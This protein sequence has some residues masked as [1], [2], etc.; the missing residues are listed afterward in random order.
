MDMLILVRQLARAVFAR[1]KK[2]IVFTT[3]IGLAALVPLAYI[4]SR[5]PPRFST[6]ATILLESRPDRTPLFQEFSPFRP[7]SVQMAILRSRSLAESVIAALPRA[8][9][10]DLVQNPYSRDYLLELKN[11]FRRLRG[12][13]PVVESPQRRAI[14]ELQN[15]RV[16]FFGATRDGIIQVQ[17]EASNARVATDIASTFIEVL[18]SRTRS[19]NVDDTRATRDFLEQQSSQLK[20]AAAASEENLRQFT[21]ARGGVKVPARSAETLNRIAQLE[22]ALAEV[23]SNRRMTQSRLTAMRSK[24]DAMPAAPPPRAPE[25]KG[26]P[27]PAQHTARI[28]RLQARLASLEGQLIDYGTRYTDEHPRVALTKQQIDEVQK[29]LAEAVKE[30]TPVATTAAAATSVPAEDRVAFAE[31]V[32]A[33]ESSGLSLAA[34]EEALREQLTNL[35]GGLSGL[36]KD[37]LEFARLTTE[38]ESSRRLLGLVGERLAGVRIREQGEMKVV[39]V[40][41]PPSPPRPAG[42]SRRVQFLGI[43]ALA[44][45]VAGLGLPAAIEYWNRPV[46]GEHDIMRLTGLP[47]LS[48]IPMLRSRRGDPTASLQGVGESRQ[49]DVFMFTE[50]FRRL[51]V[52]L[53][54]LGRES[55]LRRILVASA[56]PGEGKSTIV[57]NLG[58]AFG[59]VGKHVI[60]A[61]ADFHRPTLHRT[62]KTTGNKGFSDMLAGTGQLQESLSQVSEGVWLMPRGSSPSAL[63]RSGLGSGRLAEVMTQLATEAEYVIFDSSPILLVPDNLDLAAAADGI[64]LVVQSGVTRPRDLIQTKEILEKAGTPIIGVV[65]NQV[66]LRRIQHYYAYYNRYY[67]TEASRS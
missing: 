62:L 22:Q 20:E 8:S 19:F 26:P 2:W 24:L 49:E 9:V 34:Q 1:R 27:V 16:R 35:R 64:L 65:L 29:D 32:N 45:L 30:H 60:L 15:S 58:H 31:M 25:A 33:L 13:E 56:L 39:K 59:E 11:W 28:Q 6:T 21:L 66:P 3:L 18:M 7:L 10:E 50:A 46:E 63:S 43:A 48:V 40:I 44:S 38:A 5:E 36:S 4:M 52:E 17:A 53:Q 14:A 54:L 41:D 23:H 42:N 61:D 37:E 47:V 57:V 51:R 67:K 55:E 12:E